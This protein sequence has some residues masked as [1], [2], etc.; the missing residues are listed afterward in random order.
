MTLGSRRI[1]GFHR[2][3]IDVTTHG[4]RRLAYQVFRLPSD[5]WEHYANVTDDM[6]SEHGSSWYEILLAG[7]GVE[8]TP[9]DDQPLLRVRTF[10]G[11]ILGTTGLDNVIIV[12]DNDM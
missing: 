8:Q 6:A 5:A 10:Q 11:T 9:A 7:L 4:C 12:V 2:F 3:V 1:L